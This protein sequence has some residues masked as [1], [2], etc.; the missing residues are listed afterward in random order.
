[1]RILKIAA[2]VLFAG[3]LISVWRM[4]AILNLDNQFT[5]NDQG[6]CTL[7]EG[8]A[9]AEDI[10]IDSRSGLAYI[11]T[12][13]RRSYLTLGKNGAEKGALWVTDLNAE[14]P[15]PVAIQTDY[16]DAFHPHG[17]SLVYED[18]QK[19]LLV[20]N[21]VSTESHQIDVFELVGQSQAKLVDSI[22]FPELISPNDLHAI[23]RDM[24][25]ITN[26]HGAP[27]QTLGEKF[28]DTFRLAKAN[29]LH[30]NK[31]EV[32]EI[33]DGLYMANGIVVSSDKS[34]L[35]VAESS[36][37]VIS[38]YQQDQPNSWV[39]DREFFLDVLPDNLEL[40]QNGNLLVAS[41]VSAL[42][43]LMHTFDETV[44]SPSM[45]HRVD[46]VT[47][48]AE[49]IYADDGKTF[50]GASVAAEY[51]QHLLIGSVFDSYVDCV[52]N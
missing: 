24:F 30:Y 52:K 49:V 18:E 17:I 11:A 4:S 12:D 38:V 20:I 43:F 22:R 39:K 16:P 5:A 34:K 46:V 2:L 48:E 1:M 15:M 3:I 9:G 47:G 40:D 28:E 31:G 32:T 7:V 36:G 13:E 14:N 25:Y 41:H 29:V 50:S 27:R 37:E 10:T 51:K 45:A 8:L 44:D 19:F 21:H 6:E 35:Y 33:I 42:Y 26:D 23:S